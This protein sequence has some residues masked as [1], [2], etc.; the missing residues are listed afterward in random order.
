VLGGDPKLAKRE[1]QK[2][3]TKL[4]LTPID[5]QDE[6]SKSQAICVSS[7]TQTM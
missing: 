1:M 5:T 7:Q 3:I 6:G 4:V 2:R